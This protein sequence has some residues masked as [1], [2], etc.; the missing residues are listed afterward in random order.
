M[1]RSRPTRDLGAA[2]AVPGTTKYAAVR[3]HLLALIEGGLA[4]GAPIP[5]ER[6]LC[7]RF[8]VSRSTVRQAVD[9]LVVDGVLRRHQGKGTFVAPPKT[10]LQ[11]RLT[12]FTE[13]MRRRGMNPGAV[14]LIARTE[15]A[16]PSVAEA[17][18]LEAAAEI[19]HL[20]RLLTA[21]ASPIAIEE[22]WIPADLAPALLDGEP[23][24]S[25]YAALTE[26]GL[27]P[28]WG[29]DVIEGHA[30]TPEEAALLGVPVRA[31]ALDIT[32]RTFHR[33]L[34]V[35]YSRSLYRADRYK[36][37]VPVAAPPP[38]RRRPGA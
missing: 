20:R 17:L 11:V 36:L 16:P 21:D 37:W 1:S 15:P 33:D 8:S 27:A 38:P 6:E 5:S 2:P 28:E 23:T 19:H 25:V 34:A 14:Q 4:V 26:A 31:P 13:E 10:D 22:N 30:A 9:T 24:F 3:E 7:E 18:E 12:S 35:D 32:R 29:E